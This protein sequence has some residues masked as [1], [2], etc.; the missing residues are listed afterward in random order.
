MSSCR[1]RKNRSDT[2]ALS[3]LTCGL[4]STIDEANLR[5]AGGSSSRA[6][7]TCSAVP[8]MPAWIASPTPAV[9]TLNVAEATLTAAIAAGRATRAPAAGASAAVSCTTPG[10]AVDAAAPSSDSFAAVPAAALANAPPFLANPRA[11]VSLIREP[12]LLASIPRRRRLS[13]PSKLSMLGFTSTQ[14]VRRTVTGH[15]VSRD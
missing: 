11:N 12:S 8:V 10:V 3:A 4:R 9:A 15:L 6:F 14:A 1:G 2:D 7:F 5:A 13:S